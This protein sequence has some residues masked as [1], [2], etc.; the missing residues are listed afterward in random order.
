MTMKTKTIHLSAIVLSVAA[1]AAC[2]GPQ[3]RYGDAKAVET[4]NANYG[5]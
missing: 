5:R 4:V 3:V 1:L 2:S